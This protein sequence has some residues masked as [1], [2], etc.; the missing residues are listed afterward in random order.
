MNLNMR[1]KDY[2]GVLGYRMRLEDASCFSWAGIMGMAEMHLSGL[3][4]LVEV[5]SWPIQMV[6]AWLYK[7][8]PY[9]TGKKYIRAQSF[10]SSV[11]LVCLVCHL[12]RPIVYLDHVV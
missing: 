5:L 7:H 3:T 2:T 9:I 1:Q 10:A 6:E 11:D 12:T 8:R 4:D